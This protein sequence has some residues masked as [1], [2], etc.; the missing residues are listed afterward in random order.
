MSAARDHA[1]ETRMRALGFSKW[2]VRRQAERR[3]E[4]LRHGI[5]RRP[6]VPRGRVQP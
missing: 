3:R 5:F 6:G 2:D 1:R 4:N